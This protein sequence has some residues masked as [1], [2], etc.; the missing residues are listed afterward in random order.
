MIRSDEDETIWQPEG[1]TNYNEREAYKSYGE[2][3][4]SNRGTS[5]VWDRT[6]YSAGKKASTWILIAFALI[7]GFVIYKVVTQK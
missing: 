7:A 5:A 6:T 4:D 1:E 2:N 3:T